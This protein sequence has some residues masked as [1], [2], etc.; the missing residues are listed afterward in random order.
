MQGV[1]SID[2]EKEEGEDGVHGRATKGAAGREAGAPWKGKSA[3]KKKKGEES[4]RK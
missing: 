2:E 1:P 4:R 3:G